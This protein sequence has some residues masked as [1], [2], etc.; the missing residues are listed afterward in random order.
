MM[1]AE[2][3]W[4]LLRR[5]FQYCYTDVCWDGCWNVWLSIDDHWYD[6][7]S[8][9]ILMIA[10]MFTSVL[11]YWW[12][13][14]CL[15]QYCYTDCWDVC[16]SITILMIVEIIVE[17][18]VEI[19]AVLLHWWLLIVEVSVLLHWWLLIVELIAEIVSVFLYWCCLDDCWD[20]FSILILIWQVQYF[21]YWYWCGKLSIFILML[22]W[23]VQ[24][25]YT[26]VDKTILVFLYW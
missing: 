8:I 22:I 4:W 24:Y 3:F 15:L 7:F 14:R 20:S 25:F 26:D 6:C 11:L 16:F 19:V 18:I 5:L 13:L 17:M 21:S 12:L 1:V 2:M 23:Q 9:A 10:E